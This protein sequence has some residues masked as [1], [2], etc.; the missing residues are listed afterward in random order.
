MSFLRGDCSVV[1]VHLFFML[2]SCNGLRAVRLLATRFPAAFEVKAGC[3]GSSPGSSVASVVSDKSLSLAE[4]L[5]SPDPFPERGSDKRD[6]MLVRLSLLFGPVVGCK[7]SIMVFSGCWFSSVVE[8]CAEPSDCHCSSVYSPQ[9]QSQSFSLTFPF[10][11]EGSD[12]GG[13]RVDVGTDARNPHL[14]PLF[15]SLSN[16]PRP[17]EAMGN[18]GTFSCHPVC[19]PGLLYRRICYSTYKRE[20]IPFDEF[21][22]IRFWNLNERLSKRGVVGHSFTLLSSHVS[23]RHYGKDAKLSQMRMRPRRRRNYKL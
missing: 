9:I 10:S 14:F 6:E 3:I 21:R 19:G 4:T 12:A 17:G 2:T 23:V 13:G 5:S 1:L 15:Y 8:R 11:Q 16:V 20:L 7:S 22:D 18:G